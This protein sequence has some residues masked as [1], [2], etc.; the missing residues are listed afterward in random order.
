MDTSVDIDTGAMLSKAGFP[1][2]IHPIKGQWY[3]AVGSVFMIN[4]VT[5]DFVGVLSP[6][7]SSLLGWRDF[8]KSRA[9]FLPTAFEIIA[10]MPLG[11][12]ILF[13]LSVW[14]CWFPVAQM[15]ED[16]RYDVCPHKAAA[17]AFI[18]WKRGNNLFANHEQTKLF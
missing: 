14:E 12:R 15:Q 4:E 1:S 18:A 5:P 6:Q 8:S 9:L 11:T 16:F 7:N 3:W 17:L 2:P 10:Q 13:D